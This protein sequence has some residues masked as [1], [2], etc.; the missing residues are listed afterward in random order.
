MPPEAPLE[1]HILG[2]GPM[3]P[4]W[5][6]LA[7]R[8]GVAGRCVWRGQLPRAEALAAMRAAHVLAITSLKDLTSTVLLE[9]L[10]LGLPVICPDHCG[11]SGVV[12]DACGVKVDAHSA[13]GLAAGLADGLVRLGKD[14]AGRRRMAAAALARA[15]AFG[16]DALS[17]KIE[18]VY[19]RV[20]SAGARVAPGAA[21]GAAT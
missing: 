7:K 21:Q 13:R 18:D 12:T 20:L 15:Q 14:E 3:R 11:F 6:A 8:L 4:A 1:V 17:Q 19:A 2:D 10:A 5:Q 9:G 16:A